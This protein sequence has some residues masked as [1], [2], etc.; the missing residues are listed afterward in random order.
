MHMG[1]G[2]EGGERRCQEVPGEERKVVKTES[3]TKK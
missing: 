2:C 3:A 1:E